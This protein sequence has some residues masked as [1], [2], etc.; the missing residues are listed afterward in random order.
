MS[1]ITQTK[2][3]S[4]AW[5]LL[6]GGASIYGGIFSANK[7]VAEAGVP[8]ISYTFWQ[9][10]IGGLMLLVVGIITNN[11]PKLTSEHI[12][13][14]IIT[15]LLG[16][17]VPILILTF[18]GNRLPA[19]IIALAYTLIPG[20]TFIF[21]VI[22]RLDRPRWLSIGGLVF[23]LIGVSVLLLPKGMLPTN[24]SVLWVLLSLVMPV[25]F[26]TN[27]VY[28]AK[29]KPPKANALMRSTGLLLTAAVMT[30]PIMLA[31]DGIYFFWQTSS[32]TTWI[33][34][35]T[36]CINMVSFFCMFEIIRRA[37]AIFFGQYNYVIVISGIVWSILIFNE[38]LSF[39][40][41]VALASMLIGLYLSNAGTNQSLRE[42]SKKS[43][44]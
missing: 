43:S 29:V 31:S 22:L 9:A 1:D 15:A 28:I 10:L 13:S 42:L 33:I 34:I 35:W 17:V 14:Y 23:G 12:I 21:A 30:F 5:L 40:F 16:I 38:I 27:N 18:I 36:G 37:G 11:L 24:N 3:L 7:L 19:S 8:F 4:I 26:A 32:N 20:M 39:W 25:L 2:S 41:W 44:Q 6:V